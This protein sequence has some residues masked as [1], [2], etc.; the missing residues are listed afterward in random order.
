MTTASD[1]I[2]FSIRIKD[3]VALRAWC[4]ENLAEDAVASVTCYEIYD[5]NDVISWQAN[6]QMY[7]VNAAT[8][9]KTFWATGG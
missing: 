1:A 5:E 8:L 7:D 9:L 6:I 3:P 4:K 2:D